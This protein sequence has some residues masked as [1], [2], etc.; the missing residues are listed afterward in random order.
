[1]SNTTRNVGYAW[2]WSGILS[3][4]RSMGLASLHGISSALSWSYQFDWRHGWP[5]SSRFLVRSRCSCVLS[6]LLVQDVASDVSRSSFGSFDEEGNLV[7]CIELQSQVVIR[8]FLC[9]DSN[10]ELGP[11]RD[12]DIDRDNMRSLSFSESWSIQ[13]YRRQSQRFVFWDEDRVRSILRFCYDSPEHDVRLIE[14]FA[15][16]TE[17]LRDEMGTDEV[18]FQELPFRWNTNFRW[19]WRS[20]SFFPFYTAFPSRASFEISVISFALLISGQLH[21]LI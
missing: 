14:V 18:R 1:M 2:R 10:Q 11:S 12:L 3:T 19:K 17:I 21:W 7:W 16:V 8:I 13:D 4:A 20:Q 5:W 9:Q 15:L 6:F